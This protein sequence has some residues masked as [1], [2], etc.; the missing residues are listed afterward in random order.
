MATRSI[1]PIPLCS[2][3]LTVQLV[4]LLLLFLLLLLHS[5]ELSP[6][7]DLVHL[8]VAV[9]LVL[10]LA[11]DVSVKGVSSIVHWRLAPATRMVPKR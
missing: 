6:P 3:A 1:A 4:L 2:T 8:V 5:L 10:P 11:K 9:H 7:R